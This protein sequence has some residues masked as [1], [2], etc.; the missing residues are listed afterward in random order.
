ML[1]DQEVIDGFDIE[2]EDVRRLPPLSDFGFP[3]EDIRPAQILPLERRKQE[4][5]RQLTEFLFTSAAWS[6]DV[7]RRLA[8]LIVAFQSGQYSPAGAPTEY[9][10]MVE[11]LQRLGEQDSHLLDQLRTEVQSLFPQTR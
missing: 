10:E 9:A 7:A 1:W 3:G 5:C 2:P 11:M 4:Y 6:R 8:D